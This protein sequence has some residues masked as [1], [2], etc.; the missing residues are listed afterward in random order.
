MTVAIADV[1][2]AR[3]ALTMS[4]VNN[5]TAAAALGPAG[6]GTSKKVSHSHRSTQAKKIGPKKGKKSRGKQ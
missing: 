1:D 3:R 2:L 4:I 6:K 5:H